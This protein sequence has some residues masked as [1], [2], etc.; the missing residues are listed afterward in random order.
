MSERFAFGKN[1]SNFLSVLNEQRIRSSTEDLR[2]VV[3]DLQGKSFLDVGCGSGIHSLAA[4][5]LGASRIHSFDYD[6]D[7]VHCALELKRRFAPDANWT[8]EQGSALDENY[9]RSLEQFDVVY[10]WGVLHHTGDMWRALGLVALPVREKLMIAIYND[11]GNTSRRWHWLKKKYNQ[12]GKATKLMAKLFVWYA[13]WGKNILRDFVTLR[14]LRT[15]RQWKGYSQQRGMSPWHDVVDWAGG[16]PFEVAKP[17]KIFQFYRDRGFALE[18][19]ST[20]GG[21]LGCNQFVFI[22]HPAADAGVRHLANEI[23]L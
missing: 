7:S 5:R 2:K 17:E 10:S 13:G 11:Q 9:I 16:Y 14:P 15:I 1:W 21:G 23:A 19:L 4:L 8:A 6:E 3:G 22:R 18:Y 20:C 12:G